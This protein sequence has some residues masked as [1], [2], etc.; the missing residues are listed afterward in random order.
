MGA[1]T[2]RQKPNFRRLPDVFEFG[3]GSRLS[4]Q[5]TQR[6]KDT[7]RGGWAKVDS[8]FDAGFRGWGGIFNL[9]PQP[10]C[11]IILLISSSNT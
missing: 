7:T 5:P 4:E 11:P 3:A 1:T 6:V 8:Q 9:L 2:K 10:D